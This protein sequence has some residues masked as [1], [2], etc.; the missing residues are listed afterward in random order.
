MPGRIPRRLW[1]IIAVFVVVVCGLVVPPFVNVNRYRARVASSI[2]RAL[3]RDVTVSNIE[4]RLLPRPAMVLSTF[5]VA[6]EPSYGPEPMLRAD[7]VTAYLRLSSLWRG[8]LEIG[9]LSLESPSLN[10]VRRGDG[11]WNIEELVER[12]SHVPSAP[13]TKPSPE[14]RPRFPYIEA[15]AGRINFKVGLVKKA[16]AFSDADFALWLQ[17]ENEWGIRLE[18]RPM[19]SDVPVGDTGLLRVEGQFQRAATL[20]ETPVSLRVNFTRGQLGQ[21]TALIYGRDRGWRGAVTSTATLAG[22]P[23]SLAVTFDGRV[24]DFRRYDIALGEA[25]PLSIHCTGTYSSPDDSI[26]G[27]Q[28]Q[29]PVRPGLL[30]VRGDVIGWTGQAYNIGISAEQIPLER[31]VALAR[32]T[33][34]DLPEDLTATGSAEATFTVRK[35]LGGTP[36]WAGGG[37][38]TRFALQSR[39]LKPDLDLGEMEFSIPQNAPKPNGKHS[40]RSSSAANEKLRVVVRPFAMPLGATSPAAASG[41]FDLEHYQ[42]AL[43]GNAELARLISVAKAMGIGVPTIGLAGPVQLDLKI[44]GAWTGFAPPLPTGELKLTNATAELQGVLEPLTVTAASVSFSDQTVNVNPFA[45][46]FKD[47]PS[48]T[49]SASFPLACNSSETC[50]LHLELHAPEVSIVRLNRLLNPA[51]QSQPWYH[52]LAVGQRDENALLKLRAVGR[53]TAGHLLIGGLAASNATATLEMRSGAISLKDVRAE[54]LGG[55]HTGNWDGDFT[56]KPPKFF[57]SGTLSKVAMA[58][59]AAAMHDAWATGTLDGQYTLGLTGL[60]AAS[61]RDSATGSASFKWTGGTLRH[62]ALE[63]KASPLAFSTLEGQLAIRNGAISCDDCKMQAL[64]QVYALKGNASFA[65][66]LDFHLESAGANSYAISG[67]LDKPRVEAVPVPA[68]EAKLH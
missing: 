12:T 9:T 7:T 64:G 50:I 46:E 48:L 65:R 51:F 25:L 54:L 57:G 5:V 1:W 35:D 49:G 53:L 10:L 32:H 60:D 52:L 21:V 67:P 34:K 20:R 39:V 22:T 8:R 63:G 29:S 16:F 11:H 38:T 2:S 62:I 55:H 19:R 58:Q 17:S 23:A 33:K 3:G 36:I 56:A 14:S 42:I 13:T 4:L 45:A 43:T 27:I 26:R 18:A 59:L 40:A 68:S 44:A 47:G 31:I 24:D 28:C 37:R 6:D 41:N 66:D 30:M 61:L 15:T